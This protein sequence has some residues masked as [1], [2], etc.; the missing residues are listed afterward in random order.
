MLLFWVTSDNFLVFI[1]TTFYLQSEKPGYRH[2]NTKG[3]NN[4]LGVP[5]ANKRAS[6]CSY[7]SLSFVNISH[8]GYINPAHFSQ[9]SF[10][11]E[12]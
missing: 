11:Y 6:Q 10:I 5:T 9:K 12:M 8:I 4:L 2:N 7:M 1:K 3:V